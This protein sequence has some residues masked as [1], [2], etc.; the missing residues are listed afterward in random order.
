MSRYYS[1]LNT[2]TAILESYQG[3]EPFAHFLKK[4][5]SLHKK[6][7]SKDRK[8]IADLCFTFFRMG[9]AARDLELSPRIL[10]GKFL[11]T[12]ST[13]PLIDVLKPEWNESISLSFVEKLNIVGVL[14]KAIF[15]W[16]N[17]LSEEIEYESFC[18]SFF[19]QPE[20]FLRLRPGHKKSI[21]QKFIDSGLAFKEIG[22]DCFSL[23]NATKVEDKI[24]LNKEA[25]IQDFSSQRVG[26]FL[27]LLKE[28]N[29]KSVWDCCAASG[30]KSI[31]A[32][33]ILGNIELTVSDIRESILHNLKKRFQEAGITQFNNFIADLST[34][35]L[36]YQKKYDLIIADVP[37]TG[38][39]TW[40]RTPEQLYYFDENKIA[41]YVILQ[42]KILKNILECIKP[43]GYL[44]Y[45]TCSV[46][47]KENEE[48]VD[49][50]KINRN[51]ELVKQEVIKG[52]DQKADTMFAA[53]FRCIL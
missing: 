11:C 20:L 4:Y 46:F 27:N 52:Y 21:K 2:A 38:S 16:K 37:C 35:K 43:N 28:E 39:G 1:Y 36:S 24:Q 5:F 33:D 53:L 40:A 34:D 8:T 22:T 47:K 9:K 31:L 10:I 26:S 12:D 50:I 6:Y 42:R 32:K 44:L 13:D 18:N 45:I 51:V 19:I 3:A 7:G 41:Q 30:G 14:S 23:P 29:I 48:N 17:E 25:V 15:P 49:F